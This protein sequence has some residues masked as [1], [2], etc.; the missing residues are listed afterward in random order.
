MMVFLGDYL[1]RGEKIVPV[2]EWVLS[3]KREPNM[4]FLRGNHDEM[5]YDS[6]K[7]LRNFQDAYDL[8]DISL[9]PDVL[10]WLAN[11]GK[12]TLKRIM[13]TD[14]PAA[15]MMSRSLPPSPTAMTSRGDSP[16]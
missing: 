10:L 5:F 16:R 4:V 15:P 12:V 6:M 8:A 2:M 9:T 7:D 11:G 14:R 13:A 3:H 1:D